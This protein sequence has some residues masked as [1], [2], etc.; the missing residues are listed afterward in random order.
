MGLEGRSGARVGFLLEIAM[1]R[2]PG[3]VSAEWSG[4]TCGRGLTSS[5]RPVLERV[6]TSEFR[7]RA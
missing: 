4:S 7:N 1:V 2:G 3:L 5:R 6:G